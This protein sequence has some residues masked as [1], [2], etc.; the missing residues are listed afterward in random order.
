MS[1]QSK[2]LLAV[3]AAVLGS[4]AS[5]Q[6]V[7]TGPFTGAFSESFETP[8]GQPFP[9]CLVGRALGNTAD[10]C[11]STAPI[12]AT[13]CTGSWGFQCTM[14][15]QAGS[16]FCAT[17]NGAADWTFDTPPT[18]FGGMFGTNC[19][20]ANA[21]VEFYDTSFALVDTQTAVFPA[22]CNW[23]WVGWQLSGAPAIKRI[24]I[25]G[26]INSGAYVMM[27]NMQVDYCPVPVTYCTAKV[28]SL[29]CTPSISS[30]GT[31][32]ATSGSG[33][34]VKA[35]SVINNKPGLLIYSNTGQAAVPFSG[36]LRC[37]NAPVRRSTPLS[38]GGNP[39]PND[40][41][42]V[43]SIDMNTFAVGGLGG[44]PAAYLV[45]AGTVVDGQFWGRDNGSPA[46]RG[47][48]RGKPRRRPR[49]FVEDSPAARHGCELS[50][51]DP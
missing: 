26:H 35:T 30:T 23:Y 7:P 27:D 16:I 22:D 24:R 28:N 41:S 1:F 33:F 18:K 5:A 9:P 44:A 38:S 12:G 50:P 46:R 3:S 48:C 21:T 19:G 31:S 25:I 17:T 8:Q 2:V 14:F 13:H 51:Q 32:S 10:L 47:R 49:I 45:V 37:M 34:T 4:A 15:A 43:Y 39:P 40:C 6:I 42:G 11:D 20:I 29:G 36:G